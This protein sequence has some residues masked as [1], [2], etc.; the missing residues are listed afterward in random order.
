MRLTPW[1]RLAILATLVWIVA[2]SYVGWRNAM[3][4]AASRGSAQFQACT[5]EAEARGKADLG[6]C[7]A[8]LRQARSAARL[9]VWREVATA[10][11]TPPLIAWAIFLVGA[12]AAR[13]VLAGRGEP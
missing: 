2:G 13:W 9:E 5:V 1:W 4:D 11:L 10:A 6:P 7:A 3:G 12:G 8:A